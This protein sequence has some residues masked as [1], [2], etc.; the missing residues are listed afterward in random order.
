MMESIKE[1][2]FLIGALTGSLAAYLLGLLVSFLKRDKLRLTCSIDSRRI[3]G[4]ERA[5]IKFTYRDQPISYLHSH[6]MR[7]VN[8]GNRSLLNVPIY[9]KSHVGS[10]ITDIDVYHP[11]GVKYTKIV[12]DDIELLITFDMLQPGEYV[13]IGMTVINSPT[14]TLQISARADKLQFIINSKESFNVES[15]GVE[16]MGLV[17]YSFPYLRQIIDAFRKSGRH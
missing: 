9:I 4:S 15:F 7:L 2:Q 12:G 5:D 6:N 16:I 17:S 3:A 11:V 10:K 8:N 13:S 14:E 1:Y